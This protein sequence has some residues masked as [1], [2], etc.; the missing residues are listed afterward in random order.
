MIGCCHGN[1]N[2]LWV[3]VGSLYLTSG[4][5][6]KPHLHPNQA[7]QIELVTKQIINALLIYR[8]I[9]TFVRR[10]DILC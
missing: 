9:H 6:L 1:P 5:F 7:K 10:N 3:I 2:L 8:S 4:G